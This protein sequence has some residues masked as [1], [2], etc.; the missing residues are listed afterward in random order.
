MVTKVAMIR[1][2]VT[3]RTCLGTKWRTVET[4]RLDMTSTKAVASPM[5]R[6]FT[7]LF[8]TA[9]T[10]HMPSTCT[11]TGFCS[12]NPVGNS[13]APLVDWISFTVGQG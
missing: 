9:K 8:V 6:A 4:T 12:H 3:M 2:K 1:I 11:K 13:S 5:A 10:G 7:A